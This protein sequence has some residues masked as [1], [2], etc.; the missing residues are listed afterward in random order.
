MPQEPPAVRMLAL[1][2]AWDGS[3]LYF[4]RHLQSVSWVSRILKA[5]FS[6]L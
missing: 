5:E 2:A 6:F 3:L 1:D 4:N